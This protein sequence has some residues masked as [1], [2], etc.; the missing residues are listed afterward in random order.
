MNELS[1]AANL[2]EKTN[3]GT[4]SILINNIADDIFKSVGLK[5]D[6]FVYAATIY[7]LRIKLKSDVI[8][9]GEKYFVLA[10]NSTMEDLFQIVGSEIPSNEFSKIDVNLPRVDLCGIYYDEN[11]NFLKTE[12]TE[13]EL[14]SVYIKA[15]TNNSDFV[16]SLEDFELLV[17]ALY[18]EASGL[19][20]ENLEEMEAI[21]DVIINRKNITGSTLRNIITAP[22]QIKGYNPE[23]VRSTET[24]RK[25]SDNIKLNKAR[26]ASISTFLG[27]TKGKSNKA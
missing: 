14:E 8:L 23:S 11:G 26:K 9:P 1:G 27:F 5:Y 22:Q 24:G 20:K 12:G 2:I 10:E 15:S 4:S 3:E 18:G 17:A 21:G 25:N 19:S 6:K 16:A 7:W 13:A